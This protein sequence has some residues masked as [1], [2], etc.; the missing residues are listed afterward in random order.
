MPSGSDSYS[1]T[2]QNYG[3]GWGQGELLTPSGVGGYCMLKAAK[4]NSIPMKPKFGEA[5]RRLFIMTN[6]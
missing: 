1:I 6:L 4:C 3:H 2:V 5:L